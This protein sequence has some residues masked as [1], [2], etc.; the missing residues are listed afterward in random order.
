M[1]RVGGR[2]RESGKIQKQLVITREQ[3]YL[4]Q[5]SLAW[6]HANTFSPHT[7]CSSH[8]PCWVY[9]H[10]QRLRAQGYSKHR[11]GGLTL[12][13]KNSVALT[14]KSLTWLETVNVMSFQQYC[15]HHFEYIAVIP[16]V[17]ACA[18]LNCF[19]SSWCS[20]STTQP[21][22][23]AEE[24]TIWQGKSSIV[25]APVSLR[26]ELLPKRNNNNRLH[27]TKVKRGNLPKILAEPKD[28]EKPTC[29]V[30]PKEPQVWY[31]L[32]NTTTSLE[33]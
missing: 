14:G 7:R 1:L 23:E 9:P 12:K 25:F 21:T 33:T 4:K 24:F 8:A 22:Y 30:F 16:A 18:G 19:F 13:M 20:S 28:R 10:A 31:V 3:V 2:I 26:D 6:I 5:T 15:N 27:Y 29:A 32:R 11:S 17:S